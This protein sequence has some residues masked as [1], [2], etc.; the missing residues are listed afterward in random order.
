MKTLNNWLYK[1]TDERH[2]PDEF[3]MAVVDVLKGF[4]ND[5]SV[6]DKDQLTRLSLEY[7]AIEKS[8]SDARAFY[9]QYIKDLIDNLNKTIAGRR[10][11]KLSENELI[12]LR[13]V[14]DSI[15]HMVAK[16][17]NIWY[18]GRQESI[19][20]LSAEADMELSDKQHY[21]TRLNMSK[22]AKWL[23]EGQITA[24][25]FFRRMGGVM[26]R[27]GNAIIEAES[28]YGIEVNQ[29][30]A[31]VQEILKR[32][33]H[34][35]WANN[36]RDTLTFTT[37]EGATITLTRE[38]ALSL[39]ATDKRERLNVRQSAHHLRDSGVTFKRDAKELSLLGKNRKRPVEADAMKISRGDIAKINGWLTEE[40]KAYADAMVEYMSTDLARMGNETSRQLHG[41][42]KFDEDYYYPYKTNSD[43]FNTKLDNVEAALIKNILHTA[44]LARH[45]CI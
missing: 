14:L 21:E 18:A 13:I 41:W 22:L 37:D 15:Q 5:T 6:F 29:A 16:S 4:V 42:S 9:D 33:N 10:L 43:F 7:A 34:K 27:L 3:R 17:S 30:R 28:N 1:P 40:Q 8:E 45:G 44:R 39:Y 19:D 11:S 35:K 31:R 12:D 24:P 36:K 38:E 23:N 2:V 25:Y 20:T 26:G 32:Y